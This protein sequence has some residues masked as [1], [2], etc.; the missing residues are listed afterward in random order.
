MKF[1]INNKEN[2][3]AFISIIAFLIST[4][5]LIISI[6]NKRL[7]LTATIQKFTC[8]EFD[9]FN[10]YTFLI[11]FENSS[12][13]SVS[14]TNMFLIDSEGASFGCS[15]LHKWIGERYYPRFPE[16]DIPVT[17]RVL[18]ADFPIHIDS[19][20]VKMEFIHFKV[21]KESKIF[22]SNHKAKFHLLTNKKRIYITLSCPIE[23]VKSF[24]WNIVISNWKNYW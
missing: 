11:T 1:I 15:L 8:A 20:G 5:Q 12:S 14:I 17:E 23:P 6:L 24:F 13:R 2:I 18:T 4:S 16:T 10:S 7:K 22:N 9:N 3:L 21:N 19:N